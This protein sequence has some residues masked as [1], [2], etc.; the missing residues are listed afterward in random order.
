MG[1]IIKKIIGF[2]IVALLT[3]IVCCP[4]VTAGIAVIIIIKG[5]D[6]GV[7]WLVANIISRIIFG[8]S[9]RKFL[10]DDEF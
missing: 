9:L 2:L 1:R 3:V 7:L 10:F 8:K 4:T 5:A 6:V